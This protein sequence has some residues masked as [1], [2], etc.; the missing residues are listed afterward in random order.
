MNWFQDASSA[1]TD[2][3]S[4]TVKVGDRVTF[5]YPAGASVAQRRVP[6][7]PE[8]RRASQTKNAPNVPL[9][10]PD[11]VPPMPGFAQPPGWEGYCQFDAA[12]TYSFV[13]SARIRR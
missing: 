13:C 9:T 6:E 8:A 3:N 4:V 12:G 11:T 2:D 1:S 7:Q 5:G 10:D